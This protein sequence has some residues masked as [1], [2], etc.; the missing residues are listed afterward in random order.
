MYKKKYNRTGL[1]LVIMYTGRGWIWLSCIPD[2]AGFGYHIYR[3]NFYPTYFM[4][5]FIYFRH[6]NRIS[7]KQNL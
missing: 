4:H 2:W 1:D 3:F 6:I 5:N 7:Q